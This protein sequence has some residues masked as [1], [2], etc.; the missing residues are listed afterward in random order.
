M[1]TVF[2]EPEEN[3]F[4]ISF[5]YEHGYIKSVLLS[6]LFFSILNDYEFENF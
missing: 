5:P 2:V 3:N 1:V 4:L 6:I